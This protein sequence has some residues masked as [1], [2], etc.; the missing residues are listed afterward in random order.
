M[1]DGGLGKA[2]CY[3]LRPTMLSQEGTGRTE[4]SDIVFA[5]SGPW[6]FPH[7]RPTPLQGTTHR[8]RMHPKL[9]G[10]VFLIDSLGNLCFN[11]HPALLVDH[12]RLPEIPRS[13]EGTPA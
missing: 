8:L 3:P 6:P 9:S 1:L 4:G 7:E 5:V 2:R 10:D 11:A 13:F 12:R